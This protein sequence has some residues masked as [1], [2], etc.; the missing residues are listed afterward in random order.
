MAEKIRVNKR[1]LDNHLVPMLLRLPRNTNNEGM[2][3]MNKRNGTL[4]KTG[5]RALNDTPKLTTPT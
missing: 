1:Q 5:K 2:N 3:R 4:F